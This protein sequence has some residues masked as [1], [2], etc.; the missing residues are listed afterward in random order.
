M[1][2]KRLVCALIALNIMVAALMSA[3]G[4]S[5]TVTPRYT[6]DGRVIVR[7]SMYNSSC[8][9]AWRA[10]VEEN[11]PDVFIQWENN[12][13]SCANVL[14]LAKHGDMPDIVAIRRFECDTAAQLHPYLA[15]LSQLPVTSTFKEKY[16]EQFSY[17]GAQYWLPEPG[18]VDGMVANADMFADYGIALPTDMD[19]FLSACRVFQQHGVSPL[20]ADCA[21]SWSPTQFLEGFGAGV[22]ADEGSGWIESFKDGK[23][24]SVDEPSFKKV[25]SVLRRLSDGG[26][27]TAA[28]MTYTAVETNEMMIS[29]KAAVVRKTSD[30]KYDSSNSHRYAALPFFGST[31]E[32][33]RLCTYPVFSLAMSGGSNN[34]SEIGKAVQQVLTVMLSEGAQLALNS[35]GEGLVSYRKDVKLPVSAALD[36]VKDLMEQDKCFIR[37]LNSNSFSANA[38]AFSALISNNAGD[39]EFIDVLNSNLFKTP[40]KT[41]VAVSDIYASSLPDSSLCCDSASVAAQLLERQTGV[42]CAVIDIRETP[43]SIY[44]GDYTAA[45]VGAVVLASDVYTARL[46]REQLNELADTC[47]LCSTT[48]RSGAVEPIIEY[49][50]AAGMTIIMQKDGTLLSADPDGMAGKTWMTCTVAISANIYNALLWQNSDVAKAFRKSDRTLRDYFT[51]GFKA[52]DSLPEP[53]QYIII[54]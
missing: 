41:P 24:L 20:A 52:A 36:G 43:T 30:E 54:R 38:K 39:D 7:V 47:I 14:Y 51:L 23:A 53:E 49:P 15:D 45:D 34:R 50:A 13:N 29:G 2:K 27:L 28:D 26:A 35:S 31:A 42:D 21:E 32:D 11:C 5:G 44:R 17:N 19:S 18:A 1:K 6:D 37:V 16:L 12:R 46:T 40:D 8:F 10:Y 22:F 4:A 33:S 9:S 48:F 3:C 25:A